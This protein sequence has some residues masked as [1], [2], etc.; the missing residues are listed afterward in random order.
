MPNTDKVKKICVVSNTHWDREFRFSFEKTRY[1]LLRMLDVTLDILEKDPTYTSFTMDGHS[2]MLDDYLEIRPEKR[3][4]VEKF[5][6]EGRLVIGPYYT[7]AEQFSISHEALVRNLIFGKENVEKYGGKVGT[8]AYTPSSWGQTGQYP[9]ILSDFGLEKIMFYRGISHHESKSE[10]VWEAPDGTQMLASRF[11]IYCRYN[12]TF[13]VRR[14]V[15]RDRMWENRYT[16]GK[17]DEVP[18]RPADKTIGGLGYEAK[19]PIEVYN[20]D[21]LK[22]NIYSLLE[23]EKG[24]YTTPVFLAMNGDDI[25]LPS[26]YDT[27]IIKEAQKLFG[28]EIEIVLTDLEGFWKAAEEYLDR[29]KMT[30]LK[31]ERRAYLKEGMWTKLFPGTI[32]ARTYLKQQDFNSYTQLAY[33]AE[34]FSALTQFAVGKNN[35]D[36]LKRGWKYLITNHSHDANGGCAPEEVCQDMEYR[37]RIAK[38]IGEIVTEQ[39][40]SDIAVNLS[41]EGVDSDAIQLVVYNPLPFKRDIITELAIEVPEKLGEGIKIEGVNLQAISSGKSS[42][43]VDSQWDGPL[44]ME[45][46]EH[47][48]F[49]EFKDIPA[50]GYKV[51][52]IK[53]DEHKLLHVKGIASNNVLENEYLKVTINGNGT[54][55]VLDK[56]SV[57]IYEGLNYLT[58]QG[59][60]GNAWAHT[61]PERDRIYNSLGV[62]ASISVIDNGPLVGKIQVDYKFPVPV[63]C[64]AEQSELLTDLPVRMIYTLEKG[65]KDLKVEA[66]INNT[67]K[68]HWLR[69]NFCTGIKT[70]Y[71]YSDSHFDIVRRDVKIPDSTGWVEQAFGMQPLRSFAA[72]NDGKNGFAIMPKGLFE[73]EV[74]EDTTMALTLLRACKIKLEVADK[75]QVDPNDYGVQCQGEQNFEYALHFGNDDINTLPNHAAE[76]FA[77]V[78]CAVCGR[79]KGNLPLESSM[80]SVDNKNV[81]LTAVKPAMDGNGVV[82]RY[83]NPTDIEQMVTF[84]FD[85]TPKTIYR[86]TMGEDTLEEITSKIATPAKKIVTVKVV[87]D[88]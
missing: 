37:Y 79:G 74:F 87:W 22:E 66:T 2:I 72:V 56:E 59:E 24:H 60:V 63:K 75:K 10:Y 77:P 6:K 29:S 33:L 65:S 41:P 9:Q 19:S 42:V 27:A 69:T 62:N 7:L 4:L 20:T 25:S 46:T 38:D 57:L 8:V 51:Y 85:K 32:S 76:L 31:G 61:T 84:T 71:S 16:W 47:K 17:F 21:G 34:P 86:C 43:F 48:V 55:D 73:Y 13:E 26:Q 3:E 49:A 53:G 39:A 52:Q 12:W 70:D 45:S 15:T 18:F 1:K 35:N 81:H 83:Y 14:P 40:M 78:K 54:V 11:A 58:S 64:D 36:Y 82:I 44:V 30:V 50:L 88:E 5:V 80:V 68:D 28:D 67:A 23:T